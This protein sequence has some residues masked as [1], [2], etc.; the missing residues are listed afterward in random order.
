MSKIKKIETE[1]YQIIKAIGDGES[2]S[3]IY[4]SYEEYNKSMLDF[5]KSK[6]KQK[7]E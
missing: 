6:N 4:D 7:I 2:D 3:N 1:I 5:I